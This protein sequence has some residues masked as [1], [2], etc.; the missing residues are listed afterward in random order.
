[1]SRRGLALAA[2]DVSYLCVSLFALLLAAE[3]VNIAIDRGDLAFDFSGTLWEPA[4]DIRDGR[5]PYPEPVPQ[6][7][8]V[9]NPALYPPLL[10]FVVMPLTLLPWALAAAVWAAVLGLAVAG[11][12]Y[13]LDVR[14]P[15]CYVLALA[16]SVSVI[17]LVFGNAALLLVLLV[18]L[19][20]RW[21]D[22]WASCGVVVGLAIASKLFLWPL[23]FWLV[24]TRRYRA[25]GAAAAA[26][27]AGIL[28]PWALIGF[29]GLSAYPKLLSVA[30]EIYAGR[31]YSVATIL[32][33]LDL[34]PDIA[35]V[36][37]LALG[38]VLAAAAFFVGR[39]RT[40]SAAL[41]IAL[42]AAILGSPIVWPYYYTLLL[43]PV[44]IAR[45]RFSG[46]WVALCL[47]WIANELDHT[48]PAIWPA[49]GYMVVAVLL[50]ALVVSTTRR[51][52]IAT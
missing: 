12:L 43:V 10:M 35:A 44:A 39:R 11:A 23:L 24:G 36:V 41:T 16:P 21:R 31:S 19:S 6:E 46:V 13:A 32:R 37:P 17:G 1:M 20:W 30:E 5:S 18:A 50:A 26:A 48:R 7:V 8:A 2:R 4:L 49:L 45:P 27:T 25:A 42:L 40:D 14:D 28:L 15:R 47:F 3:T 33:A 29:N 9:G 51:S 34:D 22:R 38:V 52:R